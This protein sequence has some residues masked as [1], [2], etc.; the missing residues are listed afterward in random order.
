MD[1]KAM[2][3]LVYKQLAID[4]NCSPQDFIKKGLIFTEAI[5]LIGRRPYPFITPRLEMVTFGHGVVINASSDILPLLKNKLDGKTR[6]EVF[7]MPFVY[8]VNPYYLPDL[9]KSCAI[10]QPDNFDFILLEQRDIP[11]LYQYKGFYYSLQYN[12]KSLHPEVL[13]MIAIHKEEVVGI[14][15]ATAE[16]N[17]MW[18]LNVDV[19]PHYRGNNLA[20]ILVNTLKTEVLNRGVVPYYSTDSSNILSLRVA[21]KAGFIPTWYHSFRTRLELLY[22]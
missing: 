21:V 11:S 15:C 1:K 4:Y 19:L 8:G 5:E 20:T 18:Q 12:S 22:R 9:N 3:Q 2:L 17:S 13:A 16:C 7:N 14:A 10:K 6:Y